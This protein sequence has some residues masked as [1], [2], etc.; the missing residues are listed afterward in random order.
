MYFSKHVYTSLDL[1][2]KECFERVPIEHLHNTR[3]DICINAFWFRSIQTKIMSVLNECQS[4][5][6]I[7]LEIISFNA[8][9]DLI[10]K[11]FIRSLC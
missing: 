3:N 4:N 6:C 11:V 10:N 2:F 5:I 1:I 8:V 7:A 9:Y